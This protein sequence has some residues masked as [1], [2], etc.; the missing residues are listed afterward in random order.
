MAKLSDADITGA[1]RLLSQESTLAPIDEI[2]AESLR[3]KHP[4]HPVPSFFPVQDWSLSSHLHLQE[5]LILKKIRSFKPGSAGGLDAFKPQFFSDMISATKQHALTNESFLVELTNFT[6]F[7]LHVEI[8][9]AIRPLFFGASLTALKKKDGGIRPVAVGGAL[10]RLAAKCI[11]HVI[12]PSLTRQ[13]VPRQLGVGVKNGVEA[14]VHAAR[15]WIEQAREDTSKALLKI[16]FSNAFNEVRRD[17]VL[18]EV[19]IKFPEIFPFV[20]E[21]LHYESNLYFGTTKI[22]SQTGVQQGDPLGPALFSLAIH[23][24]V[25]K[26][27]GLELNVFYLD[28]GTIAGDIETVIAAADSIRQDAESLGLRINS[29]KCEVFFPANDPKNL[30]QLQAILPGVNV[31]NSSEALLLGSAVTIEAQ[32]PVLRLKTGKLSNMRKILGMLPSHAAFFLLAKSVSI[33]SLIYFLRCFPS[34]GEILRP[35]LDAYDTELK[36]TVAEILNINLDQSKWDQ[37]CLPVKLGGLGL[38]Q[39]PKSASSCFLSSLESSK[40][41]LSMILPQDKLFIAHKEYQDAL[42]NWRE[43]VGERDA[44][45]PVSGR[46]QAS[47]EGPALQSIQS[48]LLQKA[49]NSAHDQARLL[50]SAH[51][52]SG[53]WLQALPSAQLGLLMSDEEFQVSVALRLGSQVCLPHN[54]G[55]GS[56]K[57]KVLENGYHGLSCKWGPHVIARHDSI[58]QEIGRSLRTAGFSCFIEPDGLVHGNNKRPD[59]K[60]IM[61]WEKGLPL[62]FDVT[63]RDTFADSN[64]HRTSQRAGAA[65]EDGENLKKRSFEEA[66]PV[67]LTDSIHAFAYGLYTVRKGLENEDF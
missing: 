57:R 32:L 29:S 12:Q 49:R 52:T 7:L 44:L 4:D 54:C 2:T 38:R 45:P 39:I 63:V 17:I 26:L 5:E 65:A 30:H 31:I 56:C 59:G 19:K 27:S 11:L 6:N 62:A 46:R 37:V 50:A 51:Q 67:N 9:E 66:L 14:A 61:A 25:E 24:L 1:L 40:D 15:I 60:T 23:G 34:Y 58:K 47:W 33:P 41:L 64:I 18:S 13:F 20:C 53:Y 3:S 48:S 16:D 28:D 22:L 36:N 10:R 35:S 21:S 43:L 55:K 8:P 42:E